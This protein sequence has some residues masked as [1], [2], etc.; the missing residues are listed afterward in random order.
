[1]KR[2]CPVRNLLAV[3][4]ALAVLTLSAPAALAHSSH[5][6]HALFELKEARN[7][8]RSSS[9]NFGGHKG[10][11][12]LAVDDAIASLQRLV[13]HPHHRQ[14]AIDSKYRVDTTR[15]H[16][17]I[18]HALHQLK[19]AR[20]DLRDSRHDFGGLKERAQRDLNFAI[21]RLEVIVKHYRR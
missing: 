1:M 5:L 11:A 6:D 2:P 13:N 17:H 20:H 18:H 7:E 12:L 8:L 10:A 21:D 9:H 15:H 4:L 19:H 14:H 3:P 16:S